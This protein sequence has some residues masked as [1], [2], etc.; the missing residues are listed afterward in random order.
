MLFQQRPGIRSGD[1]NGADTTLAGRGY[2]GGDGVRLRRVLFFFDTIGLPGLNL[3][4]F[5]P[6]EQNIVQHG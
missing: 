1:A 3:G 5:P 6:F 2:D 4:V